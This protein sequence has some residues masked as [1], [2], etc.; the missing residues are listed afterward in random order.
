LEISL[1]TKSKKL[2]KLFIILNRKE[3]K[4]KKKKPKCWKVVSRNSLLKCYLRLKRKLT[5]N[6]TLKI[7]TL[8]NFSII[9][10]KKYL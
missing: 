1:K 5:E 9:L 6:T 2:K 3:E 10:K 8:M 7:L 4:R